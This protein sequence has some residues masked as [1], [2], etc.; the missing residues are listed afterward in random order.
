MA[1]RLRVQFPGAIY[2]LMN[3]GDR[4]ED[5]FRDDQDRHRFLETLGEACAKTGWRVHAFCLM[6]NHFH[7]VVE[8]PQPNLAV[9]MK[10]LLGTYTS[11]FNRRHQGSG[12]L[13]S[14][15]YKSLLVGGEGG[16]LR[17]VCDYVHLNPVRAKL[18][19]AEEP[20]RHYVWSSFP[21][22]LQASS[23]RP[24][25]LRV[26]R[27]L[28]ERGIPKDSAAG[29]RQF[30]RQMEARRGQET[31][32]HFQPIR[33][34]WCFGEET[35]RKELLAQITEQVGGHHYGPEVQESAEEQ[36]NR[37]VAE[38][39]RRRKWKESD[40][41][42]RRKGEPGKVEIARRL[43]AETAMT[44]KWIAQ[45]LCIGT[46]THLVHLLYWRDRKGQGAK[47]R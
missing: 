43:R 40:L 36:A 3:R 12:H 22:Y 8:T 33:Q 1:R 11:R 17:T 46:K 7:L 26:E 23:K 34:G 15:R 30:E 16:Y 24:P 14:G 13:F 28:G 39:L 10:W 31:E 38:E 44:L 6:R 4:R 20:L 18:L 2:H 35:F 25:W 45:R 32:G 9:G 29:R 47:G 27:L 21:A 19:R 42:A 41:S 5:I 37:L